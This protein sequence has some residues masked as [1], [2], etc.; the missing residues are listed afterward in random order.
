[1]RIILD[2]FENLHLFGRIFIARIEITFHNDKVLEH[3]ALLISI[4]NYL[5]NVPT[6]TSSSVKKTHSRIQIKLRQCTSR[7]VVVVFRA[8]RIKNSRPPIKY[9]YS[10]KRAS[11]DLR[12]QH[13]EIHLTPI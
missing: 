6:F 4:H 10:F 13:F 8:N 2:V 9:T 5:E 11:F 7:R 3:R 12:R 1:M